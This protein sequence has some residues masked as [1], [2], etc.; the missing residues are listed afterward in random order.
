PALHD[1]ERSFVVGGMMQWMHEV[2]L[3]GV[4]Q[5]SSASHLDSPK[6]TG[7]STGNS[8]A[9]MWYRSCPRRATTVL[10][11]GANQWPKL[12]SRMRSCKDARYRG[13]GLCSGSSHSPPWA[14]TL[15]RSTKR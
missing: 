4:K 14:G 1:H 11:N 3:I 2:A 13:R 8:R 7:V 10:T 9:T 12:P 5:H 15:L 6:T